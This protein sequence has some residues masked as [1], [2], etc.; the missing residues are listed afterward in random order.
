MCGPGV[1]AGDANVV[2]MPG[3]EVP[4]HQARWVLLDG[5]T[6]AGVADLGAFITNI[7]DS[8]RWRHVKTRVGDIIVSTPPKSGTTWVQEIVHS[9][10]WP[11]GDAPGS[12]RDLARWVD[13]RMR[14]IDEVVG[15][16]AAQDHRRSIK[17]HSPADCTPFDPECSYIVVYRDGRDALMSWGNHRRHMRPEAVEFM[18]TLAAGDGLEPIDVTF[19]GDYHRLY[20]EWLRICS[21]IR[22]LGSWW[23]RRREPNV[24]FVHYADLAAALEGEMRRI[25]RFLDLHVAED[26][27]RD[28][29]GRCTLASMRASDT[30]LDR[31]YVG[32]AASFFYKGGGGRWRGVVPD[33]VINDYS[34]RAAEDLPTEAARWLEHGSLRLGVRP[35][36]TP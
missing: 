34:Q 7:E 13:M 25:A 32:G 27:W 12:R 3:C 28:V 29:V 8:R 5:R 18:N 17:T 10:L 11:T 35:T 30:G 33:T 31:L 26:E 22:H 24:L 9:L 23:P 19:E 6:I 2:E 20:E 1:L 4:G 16:L 15:H 21:P 14:P 36:E